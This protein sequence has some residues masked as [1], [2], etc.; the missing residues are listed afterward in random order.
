MYH[1]IKDDPEKKR[2]SFLIHFAY[3]KDPI[4]VAFPV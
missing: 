2:V 1:K 3:V 4:F